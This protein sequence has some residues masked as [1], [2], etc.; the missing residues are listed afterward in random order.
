[1]DI[2]EYLKY[3][4]LL[5]NGSTFSL[6]EITN[7]IYQ[8]LIDNFNLSNSEFDIKEKIKNAFINYTENQNEQNIDLIVDDLVKEIGGS[9]TYPKNRE[10]SHT[11]NSIK[12]INSKSDTFTINETVMTG[13][14]ASSSVDAIIDLDEDMINEITNLYNEVYNNF[15]ETEV[16]TSGYVSTVYSPYQADVKAQEEK[17]V[18]EF[19]NIGVEIVYA[20]NRVGA[21][22][23]SI[24]ADFD[25]NGYNFNDVMNVLGSLSDGSKITKA[26]RSF[27]ENCSNATIVDYKDANGNMQFK[28]ICDGY[29]YDN[30][31]SRLTDASGNSLIVRYY[32]PKDCGDVSKL[33]TVTMLAGAGEL[34]VL[35]YKEQGILDVNT[36]AIIV[37]P[38]KP[39]GS[40]N[41]SYYQMRNEIISSTKFIN[42]LANQ[43]DGCQNIIGGCSAGGCAALKIAASGGDTYDTAICINNAA[44]VGGVNANVGTKEQFASI[45]DLQKLDGKN[46]YFISTKMDPN[47]DH[48]AN[49]SSGWAECNNITK[50]YLYTGVELTTKNCPNSQVYLITNAEYSAFNNI[51]NSNNN[52][53]YSHNYWNSVIGNNNYAS[54]ADY[55]K[56]LNDLINNGFTGYN[57]YSEMH[58]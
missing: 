36:N 41:S 20:M 49:S 18:Q 58:V 27:F 15:M 14:V 50:S 44:L 57:I 39:S 28:V 3:K 23:D 42:K 16:E 32:V 17:G 43:Q 52:F 46:I 34:S 35:E 55:K 11:N 53:H 26:D 47:L 56:V 5:M 45:S 7:L 38:S 37:M 29:T 12:N 51:N 10:N 48:Y 30:K 9:S 33:N 8:G 4:I 2:K 1:M 6:D 54:H 40:E 31:T 25:T 13:N 24:K 19:N 21:V 22:D